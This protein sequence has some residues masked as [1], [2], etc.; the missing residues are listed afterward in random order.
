MVA[1]MRRARESTGNVFFR[2]AILQPL[3]IATQLL[4]RDAAWRALP[5][6]G[7]TAWRATRM[8]GE[9]F[10]R[11]L[12]L[13]ACVTRMVWVRGA[14]RL[15]RTMVRLD[16]RWRRAAPDDHNGE[17]TESQKL[18]YHADNDGFS[19]DNGL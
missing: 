15:A 3:A 2:A 4:P 13:R 6:L 7:A 16:S 9:G 5:W 17:A 1:V 11:L 14:R 12:R 8:T 10:A 18:L 19:H